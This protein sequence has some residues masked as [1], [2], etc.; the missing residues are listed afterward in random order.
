MNLLSRKNEFEADRFAVKLGYG[1]LLQ[2]ALIKLQIENKGNMNPDC[3][4]SAMN[5]SHPPL[6][7][8]LSAIKAAMDKQK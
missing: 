1:D 4:Y 6:L 8:R 2:S 5:Y 3:M 7:E